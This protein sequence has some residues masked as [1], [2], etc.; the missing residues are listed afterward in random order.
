MDTPTR[1]AAPNAAPNTS[2]THSP[3]SSN[4]ARIHHR[5]RRPP[6]AYHQH[7]HAKRRSQRGLS[8][9]FSTDDR[10][11]AARAFSRPPPLF[12]NDPACLESN[13]AAT[14]QRRPDP[15]PGTPDSAAM[16]EEDSSLRAPDETHPCPQA[17]PRATGHPSWTP[18][19]LP[20]RHEA[21][22]RRCHLF[23]TRM[24]YL[25][26]TT[27]D[28]NHTPP[29]GTCRKHP[30]PRNTT[31]PHETTHDACA[32]LPSPHLGLRARQA[33]STPL[34]SDANDLSSAPPCRPPRPSAA[35]TRP[36]IS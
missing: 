24:A 17:P 8:F 14:Q 26:R 25:G 12:R 30:W 22:P 11:D 20:H 28:H 4:P 1:L 7:S 18:P 19:A 32:V 15:C 3:A 35:R 31:R 23:T 36:K 9:S 5:R 16:T 27:Y 2:D 33:D 13:S 10:C 6:L 34:T 21:L 29:H